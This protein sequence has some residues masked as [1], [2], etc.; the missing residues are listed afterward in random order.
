MTVLSVGLTTKD[1]YNDA[2]GLGARKR[3]ATTSVHPG[4]TEYPGPQFLVSTSLAYQGIRCR[5]KF[6]RSN[7]AVGSRDAN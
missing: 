5:I 2:N 3:A 6:W 4:Y 1:R 7:P